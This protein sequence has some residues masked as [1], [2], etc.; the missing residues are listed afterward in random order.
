VFPLYIALKRLA[1]K[2][3]NIGPCSY[4]DNCEEDPL[5]LLSPVHLKDSAAPYY[6]ANILREAI[7]RGILAEG[8][9]LYQSQLAERLSV[10]P[11]PLREA[12]RLLEMEGLVD[13]NGRRGAVV[14]GLCWEDVREIYEMLTSLETCVLRTAFPF[15]T[16][17]IAEAAG[18]LLDEMDVQPDCAVWR[19]QNTA[20]HNLL[21]GPAARPLTLDNIARLRRQVDRYVRLHLDSMRSDSQ[22]QHRRILEA[23]LAGDPAAAVKALAFHLES[24][25]RDL[26]SYMR[27]V[28][29]Q[30]RGRQTA[31]KR[32]KTAMPKDSDKWDW[33]E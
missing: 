27:R 13:F 33:T 24:A 14:R 3:E 1:S 4:S 2:V 18:R 6:I 19:I 20:F 30:G 28:P 7:Y 25:S 21:C 32:Q 15:I 31:E 12:L 22:E 16:P 26:Q 23:V 17:D 11:I 9:A 29:R 10:S 8:S 5:K